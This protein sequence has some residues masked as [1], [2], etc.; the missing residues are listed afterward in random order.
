LKKKEKIEKAIKE[1]GIIIKEKGEQLKK[2]RKKL[3]EEDQAKIRTSTTDPEARIMKMADGGFRPAY[4][5]QFSTTNLG[6][7]IVGV[8]V[9]NQGSDSELIPEMLE[10]MKNRYS[11]AV[12]KHLVDSG[13]NAHLSV[14]EIEKILPGCK[15]YSPIKST[16]EQKIKNDQNKY[17]QEYA[18][19]M[20]SEEGKKSYKMRCETAEFVNAQ[21]RNNGLQQFFVRGINK[22]FCS[23]LIYALTHN[24]QVL[25]GH[26]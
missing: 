10:Q 21:A 24:M 11:D 23:T 16:Y 7:A 5:V 17:V 19:R 4:N 22:V 9:T 1:Q 8:F 26:L 25:F 18:A 14:E 13:Y 6:K 3:K 15:I 20:G 12:Q 2:E